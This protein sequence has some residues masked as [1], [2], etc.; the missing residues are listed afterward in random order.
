MGFFNLCEDT[1]TDTVPLPSSYPLLCT[2]IAIKTWYMHLYLLVFL[3]FASSSKLVLL[4]LKSQC[5]PLLKGP[6]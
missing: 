5:I 3:Y 6:H 4:E 2:M 1:G